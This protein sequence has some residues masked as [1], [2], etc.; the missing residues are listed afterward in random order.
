MILIMVSSFKSLRQIYCCND[1]I[2][3]ILRQYQFQI[4]F[5]S[6]KSLKHSSNLNCLSKMA[7]KR[8]L[9]NKF[10]YFF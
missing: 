2:C 10:S 7:L 3:Q 4:L 6:N 9:K 1:P 8:T 5:C